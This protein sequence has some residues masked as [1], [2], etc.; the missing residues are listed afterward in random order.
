MNVGENYDFS[1]IVRVYD[2]CTYALKRRGWQLNMANTIGNFQV[3]EPVSQNAT[4]VVGKVLPTSNSTVLVLQ[5]QSLYPTFINTVNSTTQIVG[6]DSGAISNVTG[7]SVDYI[8]AELDIASVYSGLNAIIQSNTIIGMGSATSMTIID[9]GFAYQDKELVSFS[10]DGINIGTAQVNLGRFGIG[11]GFY[12][13]QN[14]FVSA[15]KKLY[16]GKYYQYFSYE[17]RSSLAI[18]VYKD[19][20]EQVL[21]TAGMLYFG[22]LYHKSTI[23]VELDSAPAI[24]TITPPD[25]TA[26]QANNNTDS[27]WF[28]FWS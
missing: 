26:G 21:H 20:L 2:P 9:S 10:E 8:S 15:S 27:N 4:H 14:G 19:I 7:V 3:G 28:F 25:P 24:I 18:D 1:P 11:S 6:T 12:T 17:V 23:A 13:D 5:R 22:A 16:D